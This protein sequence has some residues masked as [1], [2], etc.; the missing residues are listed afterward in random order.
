MPLKHPH[1]K[2]SKKEVCYLLGANSYQYDKT[3]T[4]KGKNPTE[5]RSVLADIL[6]DDYK[7][8]KVVE[9]RHSCKRFGTMY[10]WYLDNKIDE[11]ERFPKNN[12]PTIWFYKGIILQYC[13]N[14][15]SILVLNYD[16][17]HINGKLNGEVIYG[18]LSCML[19]KLKRDK[20][21]NCYD[22]SEDDY[23]DEGKEHTNNI[24]ELFNLYP[25]IIVDLCNISDIGPTNLLKMIKL[26]QY[27]LK[28]SKQ[29]C[30]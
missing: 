11:T 29:V 19:Y 15:D 21:F 22:P 9:W 8:N 5:L 23:W 17:S 2:Y 28:N 26:N 27:M 18:G 14:Y 20:S 25:R 1:Y 4:K 7:R 12:S 3:L 24:V 30:W 10:E 16:P 13:V 6:D